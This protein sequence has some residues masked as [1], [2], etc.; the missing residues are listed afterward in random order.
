M[1]RPTRRTRVPGTFKQPVPEPKR[2]L[3]QEGAAAE[4]L[5]LN[6]GAMH[7]ERWIVGQC[8]VLCSKE[9]F[10]GGWRWH[11]SI[12]HPNRYP[13]WDEVKSA[14]YGIPLVELPPGRAFAQVLG[15][16]GQGEWVDVDANCFHLYEIDDPF[17]GSQ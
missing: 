14:V 2:D 5:V 3:S 15:Q 6:I 13:T 12:S 10:G 7:C 17:R 1:A 8:T 16:V 4:A 9:P 11:V